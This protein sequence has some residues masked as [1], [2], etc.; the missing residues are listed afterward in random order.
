VTL[1]H[2]AVR[3][4]V[5]TPEA[6]QKKA[7]TIAA[8]TMAKRAELKAAATPKEPPPPDQFMVEHPKMVAAVDVD[9]V[10]LT[11]QFVA[12]NGRPF[13]TGLQNRESRNP[14]FDF[15]KASHPLFTYFTV[16]V[17]HYSKTLAPPPGIIEKLKKI[18]LDESAGLANCTRKLEWK[19]FQ[20][21][22]KQ[23][24]EDILNE[25]R[26]ANAAVDWHDFVVVEVLT[27]TP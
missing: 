2:T 13:L 27:L 17:D 23:K 20:D 24:E 5:A 11:S 25:E 19:Q 9:F 26:N 22:R 4:A 1:H 21:S 7:T 15:L 16:M 18:K 12:K 14:Q 3:D 6:F 8:E 10:K